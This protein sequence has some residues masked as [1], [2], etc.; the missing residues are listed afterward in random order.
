MNTIL[1]CISNIEKLVSHFKYHQNIEEFIQSN[2]KNAL[3]YSFKYL[4]ENLWQTPGNK[5]ILPEYNGEN[6]S[7]KYFS[8][9]E[10][11]KKI[12]NMS[13]L[14]EGP[15]ANDAK[16][17]LYFIIMTLHEELNKRIII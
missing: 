17:L 3:T 2:G 15:H 6:S 10:F 11:K 16:D 7:N 1:Q 8:L 13:S 14:F 12:S 9:I 5:Y 4:I